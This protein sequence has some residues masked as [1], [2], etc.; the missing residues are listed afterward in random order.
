MSDAPRRG[1]Q[2]PR[3][4]QSGPTESDRTPRPADDP[5]RPE[6]RPDSPGLPVEHTIAAADDPRVRVWKG[7]T[8][9]P[10]QV[11]SVEA[12]RRGRNVL[13]SAPT[14]AGKTLVAEYAIHEAV[15]AGQR[16]IYTAPI[17]ALSNQKYRDFRDDPK[18]DVGLM[19]GDV[20]IHPAAQVLI[21]TTEILR[22]AIFEDPGGLADVAFVIFDEVHFMDDVERG[23]VWEESIIFA[24]PGVRFICLSATIS[25]LDEVGEWIG[26]IRPQGIEIVRSEHRP[27]PLHFRFFTERSGGFDPE[28]VERI[29]KKEKHDLRS[30]KQKKTSAR[31]KSGS[32]AR[33]SVDQPGM[34]PDPG[35][36]FDEL[37]EQGLRPVLVFCFSRK[38]CERLARRNIHRNLLNAEELQRMQ[39]LQADLIELFQLPEGAAQAEIF[40]LARGGVGYHHAG[41][42]PADKEIVERMF[43]SGLLRLLFTTETFA[44]GINMPARVV[45][46]NSLK[47]FD[48]VTFD[49]MRTRDFLQMAGRAGRQGLDDEGLVYSL[50]S[51][52]D[53]FE[54]PLTRL[55]TGA[56]ESVDSRF[57]LSFS[58]ILHLVD[59]LGRERLHIAWEKSFNQF[60]HRT[61]TG[62][63][64]DKNK[65]RQR[66][67]VEARLDFLEQLGY[68]HGEELT[69]RGRLAQRINGYELQITELLFQ[70]VLEELSATALAV[71]FVG[72]IH[73]QRTRGE[74]IRIPQKFY[75]DLRHRV[76]AICRQL[77]SRAYQCQL[78]DV[79]K[80]PD[81]GLTPAVIAWMK[82]ADFDQALEE[83]EVGP[84]DLCRALRMALQLMR[85]VRRAIDKDWDL[86]E[87]LGEARLAMNRDEVD[88]RRQLE[89][90]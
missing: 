80:R 40:T 64:Q 27:V 6:S 18:I 74:P 21:M 36:L 73:E 12:I 84:G 60:Q 48:G 81:W 31:R 42:L 49:Y 20:T 25:N 76:D 85:Q 82:G 22:N 69:S 46:F 66:K 29:R 79:P 9:S 11:Q 5:P 32:R 58:S 47:K 88:A 89:L 71:V 33:W 35:P 15:Q 68:L 52:K 72:L 1:S 2:R 4:K 16:V 30:R 24:P 38:D 17:K 14:G 62:K 87:R 90:G 51:P 37:Q 23:T 83:A 57:R 3:R 86:Y 39:A 45:I 78:P 70:G 63:Q 34:P 8:L 19:T 43:T 44:L 56:S 53:L 26:E 13:V 41:M 77:T 65:R 55:L 50:L 54:A 61:E 10:F 67:Q 75:G 28:A 7:F 59:R